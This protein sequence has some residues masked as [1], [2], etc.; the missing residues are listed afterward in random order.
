MPGL[1]LVGLLFLAARLDSFGLP[2]LAKKLV[3]IMAICAGSVLCA[4]A[5]SLVNVHLAVLFMITSF[6][7]YLALWIWGAAL[8]LRLRRS[9]RVDA[10]EWWLDVEALP[11]VEWTWY[12][13]LGDGRV[14]LVDAGG[15]TRWFENYADATFWLGRAGFVRKIRRWL[16]N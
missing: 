14:E 10:Y 15:G 13:R 4:I 2:K 8:M 9:L 11:R 7:L 1:S 3:T 12:A 6:S 16:G 5:G